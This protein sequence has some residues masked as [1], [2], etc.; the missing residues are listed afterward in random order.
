MGILNN[1]TQNKC[2][3]FASHTSTPPNHMWCKN[4]ENYLFSCLI[5]NRFYLFIWNRTNKEINFLFGH[6][7]DHKG[8]VRAHCS[9]PGPSLDHLLIGVDDLDLNSITIHSKQFS[10]LWHLVIFCV[11]WLQNIW[12]SFL[13]RTFPQAFLIFLHGRSN[14]I[15]T[16]PLSKFDVHIRPI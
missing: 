16:S 1:C 3:S 11:Q 8:R 9:P 13:P 15:F 14:F 6:R 7:T 12:G 2:I 10:L 5:G 4:H